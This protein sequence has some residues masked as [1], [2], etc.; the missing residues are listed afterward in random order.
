LSRFFINM[1]QI[2]FFINPFLAKEH[3]N[4]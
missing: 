2:L 3:K 4:N 1:K